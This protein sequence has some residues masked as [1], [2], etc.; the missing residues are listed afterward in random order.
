MTYLVF[1]TYL[2]K[3]ISLVK[4]LIK[5]IRTIINIAKPEIVSYFQ[6]KFEGLN[7]INQLFLAGWVILGCFI[8]LLSQ[9]EFNRHY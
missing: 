8:P 3:R 4:V 9:L 6:F 2:V 5:D 1:L 7:F